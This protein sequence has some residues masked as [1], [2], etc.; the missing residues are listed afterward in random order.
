MHAAMWFIARLER[1]RHPIPGVDLAD[2]PHSFHNAFHGRHFHG[3]TGS[4]SDY[5]PRTH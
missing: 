2:L 4:G 1:L 3:G 5:K